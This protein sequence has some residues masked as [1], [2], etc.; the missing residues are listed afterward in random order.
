MLQPLSMQHP[1]VE[2]A[3]PGS[4][5]DAARAD[6]WGLLALLFIAPP[7][8]Q[9][10]SQLV[11]MLAAENATESALQLAWSHLLSTT[12]AVT[13]EEVLDE[14]EILFGGTGRPAVYVY[15]SFYLAGALHEK[16][17]A[18]LRADLQDIG[19]ARRIDLGE[20]ED[21]FAILAETMRFLIAGDDPAVCTLTRQRDLFQRHIQPW[22]GQ[23]C[24]AIEGDRAAQFYRA[25][26]GFTRE[27][28]QVEQMAFDLLD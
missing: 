3:A 14:F 27:F 18:R 11:G 28:L 2:L 6:L 22:G 15:G 10:L 25:L 21:H 19:L 20:S 26:A 17:L 4:D 16:P 9:V 24:D 12:A 13:P 23:M 1:D 8:Q 5:E 7:T